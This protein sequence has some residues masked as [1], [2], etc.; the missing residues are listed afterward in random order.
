MIDYRDQAEQ[1][2]ELFVESASFK[3]MLFIKFNRSRR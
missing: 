1:F 2:Q 3:L